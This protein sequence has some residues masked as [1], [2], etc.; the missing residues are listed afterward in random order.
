[1]EKISTL[2]KVVLSIINAQIQNIQETMITQQAVFLEFVIKQKIITGSAQFVAEK[3]QG[4]VIMETLAPH[5]MEVELFYQVTL[6][7][8]QVVVAQ[9]TLQQHQVQHVQDVMAQVLFQH[10]Q[11]QHVQD[12]AEMELWFV[13]LVVVL[14]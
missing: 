4:H 9:G 7:I 2:L 6:M 12:V 3:Q 5:V 11:Q 8:V 13:Q 1:M 14:A 10:Q